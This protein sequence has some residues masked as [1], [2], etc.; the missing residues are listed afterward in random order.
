ME[1]ISTIPEWGTWWFAVAMSW[2]P[3]SKLKKINK[4]VG[5]S[6]ERMLEDENTPK[7]ESYKKGIEIDLV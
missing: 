7:K 2:N 5:W 3:T 4:T 1:K 6:Y